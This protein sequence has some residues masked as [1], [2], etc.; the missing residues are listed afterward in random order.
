[1]TVKTIK[2]TGTEIQTAVTEQ[3]TQR[4]LR[5]LRQYLIGAANLKAKIQQALEQGA[6]VE[7]GALSAS[8]S[9]TQRRSV[10]WKKEFVKLCGDDAA[11]DLIESAPVKTSVK[12]NVRHKEHGKVC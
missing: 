1:M 9:E 8:L 6:T 11:Q 7:D 4:D 12:L 5:R 2:I 3:V 10:S